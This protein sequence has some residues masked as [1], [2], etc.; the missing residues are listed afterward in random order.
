MMV[1]VLA[2]SCTVKRPL[3]EKGEEF[4]PEI[5]YEV[6]PNP[7][8]HSFGCRIVAREGRA[9]VLEKERERM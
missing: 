4:L 1:A 8:P 9:G 2:W 6:G 5:K 7:K 3:N